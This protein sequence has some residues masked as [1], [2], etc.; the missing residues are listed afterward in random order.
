MKSPLFALALSALCLFSSKAWAF[1]NL[2]FE[3]AVVV[4]NDP[5]F[6]FLDWSLAVPGW[7]HSSGSDT[8]I[9]Y[10]QDIHLASTQWFLLA[11]DTLSG[12]IGD[13]S[14]QGRYSM[15]LHSGY[16]SSSPSPWVDAAI[17]QTGL[18]PSGTQSFTLQAEGDF[19][20]YVN[21][22][23]IPMNFMSGNVYTGNISNYAGTTSEIKIAHTVPAAQY[24]SVLVDNIS[25][26]TT[27]APEP[28]R[29]ML[30][31][32]GLVAVMN[33]RLGHASLR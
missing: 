4:S 2:N 22:N 9:V 25:F 21:G 24:S 5:N 23:L 17:W 6:G 7:S 14:L 29:M 8:S 11:D 13:Y 27:P 15:M 32:L 1:V 12:T 10:Y 30:L 20:V 33:R 31:L 18:I 26:S 19:S 3:S 16:A 28:S